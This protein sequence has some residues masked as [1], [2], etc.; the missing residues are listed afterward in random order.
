MGD[1][2]NMIAESHKKEFLSEE[3]YEECISHFKD[4]HPHKPLDE[5]FYNDIGTFMSYAFYKNIWSCPDVNSDETK[6]TVY[7]EH[8]VFLDSEKLYIQ[9]VK[10]FKNGAKII[11][12]VKF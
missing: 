1:C 8:D 5:Y 10:I 9:N 2:I 4:F 11:K 12:K 6:G 7:F 3:N